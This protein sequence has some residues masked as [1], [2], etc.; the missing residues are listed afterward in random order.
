MFDIKQVKPWSFNK[1]INQKN[2]TL[3][4][5]KCI[6]PL[7][8]VTL[9]ASAYAGDNKKE[10]V[11]MDEPATSRWTVSAGATVSSI[12]TTFRA[13]P[14][15]VTLLPAPDGG[16]TA[17]YNGSNGV[18]NYRD[19]SV[20][21]TNS[22]PGATNF[23]GGTSGTGTGIFTSQTFHSST[24]YSASSTGASDTDL[25]VG[26][27]IKGAYL[28]KEFGQ[29]SVSIFG[30]YT[31][32]TAFDSG[33]PLTA[34]TRTDHTLVYQVLRGS[35]I[36][37]S[38][39]FGLGS[40]NPTNT[41]TQTT[42]VG[43]TNSSVNIYMHTFALG[44]DI[45]RTL[46]DRVHLV[47]SSGPTL[48]LFDTDFTTGTTGFG[49]GVSRPM[50]NSS[51]KFRFGWVGQVGVSVDL[52]AKKRY[53]AEASGDYHWVVPFD[54]AAGGTSARVNASSWGGNLGLGVRF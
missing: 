10:I 18:Q 14:V 45:N 13:N 22:P 54:V 52:D 49:V 36:Y 17:L 6:T 16:S 30:Q 1:L 50:S 51:E 27:Y 3:F 47:L 9:M 19:G 39:V 23:T 41:A 2:M 11:P 32:T 43:R 8:L 38:T 40:A 35:A 28:L 24:P 29:T 37:N 26:P 34:A 33:S 20:G 4:N 48:N 15:L 42:F 7:A 12:K 21:A 5:I 44:F 25:S 46:G 53:Y 31:F